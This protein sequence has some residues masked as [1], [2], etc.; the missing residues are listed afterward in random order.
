MQIIPKKENNRCYQ[1][2]NLTSKPLKTLMRKTKKTKV[3]IKMCLFVDFV[4]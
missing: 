2:S 3:S 4:G 1:L